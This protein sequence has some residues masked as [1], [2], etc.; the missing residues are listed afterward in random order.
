MQPLEQAVYQNAGDRSR[1]TV[2]T[3]ELDRNF[4]AGFVLQ[5][6]AAIG[7]VRGED[8]EI[9]SI[10]ESLRTMHLIHQIFGV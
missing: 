10:K 2:D 7:R 9:A 3:S 4:K 6:K 8:V 5:A 1:Q